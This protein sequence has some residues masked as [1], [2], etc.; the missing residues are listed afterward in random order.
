MKPMRW[1]V[2]LAA[3]LAAFAQEPAFEVASVKPSTPK[4]LIIAFFT[5]PG[6]RIAVTNYSLSAML[7]EAFHVQP[8]QIAGGP[9]WIREDRYNLE[10]KPPASSQS[11]KSNPANP[12]L[13]PNNEQRRMLQT[14]LIDRFQLKFHREMREGP[15]YNLSRGSKPLK[16]TPAK[17]A[18]D[19]PWAGGLS[20]GGFMGDGVAGTNITMTLLAERLGPYLQ[21]RVIDQTGLEGSFDFRI[22]YPAEGS[23]P[24]VLASIFACLQNLGLKLEAGKG[25]VETIVIDSVERP[26]AN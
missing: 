10:A 5:Y 7:Q 1:I 26:T 11:S 16:L 9:R 19:Y 24:D 17:N 4:D 20:G 13:P 23:N 8:F 3:A 22:E 21:R 12:K 2:F 6:G 14:L 25:P 18:D 15:V